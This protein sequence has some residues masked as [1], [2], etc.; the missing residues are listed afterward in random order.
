M[1]GETYGIGSTAATW[2]F[3]LACF[4]SAILFLDMLY[5]SVYKRPFAWSLCSPTNAIQRLNGM[6]WRETAPFTRITSGF[7]FQTGYTLPRINAALCLLCMFVAYAPEATGLP[8]IRIT[9]ST[10]SDFNVW[11]SFVPIVWL[12]LSRTFDFT[13][14]LKETRGP[15]GALFTAPVAAVIIVFLQSDE[16]PTTLI[17]ISLLVSTL[18]SL[19]I[20]MMLGTQLS[21][22][23]MHG[24]LEEARRHS[25][26]PES[27]HETIGAA[28]SILASSG[29]RDNGTCYLARL[30]FAY[31]IATVIP[32]LFLMGSRYDDWTS[33]GDVAVAITMF[34]MGPCLQYGFDFYFRPAAWQTERRLFRFFRVVRGRAGLQE[35]INRIRVPHVHAQALVAD[36]EQL[37]T[38]SRPTTTGYINST[39]ERA[40]EYRDEQQLT[41]EQMDEAWAEFLFEQDRR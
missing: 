24:V 9:D 12:I 21:E 11:F 29:G 17:V 20:F 37:R 38:P 15:L 40:Q 2:G 23:V 22:Y 26:P 18:F 3:S 27:T 28:Y 4:G 16:T 35:I 30:P 41:D 31:Y 36:D 19:T 34:V 1:T 7:Q 39:L 8:A 14:S 10:A 5:S 32:I 33:T 6:N 25:N 13:R